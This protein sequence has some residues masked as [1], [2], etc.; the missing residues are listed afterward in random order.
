MAKKGPNEVTSMLN[1]SLLSA[2]ISQENYKVLELFSDNC[3]GQNKNHTLSRFCLALTDSGKFESV[4]EF[5]PTR[6]HSYLACDRDL[7]LVKRQLKNHDRLYSMDEIRS[8]ILSHL[9][10]NLWSKFLTQ[11]TSRILQHGGRHAIKNLVCRR[12]QKGEEFEKK[13]K[14]N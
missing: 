7:S 13:I 2:S 11:Q 12:R 10:P 4:I 9:L 3:G 8:I 6:G 14:C 5:F 1:N